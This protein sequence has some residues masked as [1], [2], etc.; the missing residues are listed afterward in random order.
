M[1]RVITVTSSSRAPLQTLK[2]LVERAKEIIFV[3]NTL[4]EKGIRR[5][6]LKRSLVKYEDGW[7]FYYDTPKG[8]HICPRCGTI[9]LDKQVLCTKCGHVYNSK[10]KVRELPEVLEKVDNHVNRV[11]GLYAPIAEDSEDPYELQFIM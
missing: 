6:P 9:D 4:N 5:F 10:F 11:V 8:T 3:D 7:K 1:E 2:S